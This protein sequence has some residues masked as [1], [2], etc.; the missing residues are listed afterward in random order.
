VFKDCANLPHTVG[1]VTDLDGHLTSRALESLAAEL[2]RREHLLAQAGAKDIEDYLETKMPDQEPMPR[3]VIIIDEFA[4]LVQEL[5]D[6]VAGLVDIA[7]RGRSL[8]V[9]LLLATQRPAGIVNAQ[10]KSNT[11]LRIALRVSDPADSADVIDAP[12]AA[13][14]SK[15][16]PGR[17]I[18]RLGHSSLAGFQ[19]ARVG[20]RPPGTATHDVSIWAY[21]P[22]QLGEPIPAPQATDDAD[23]VP[24]DLARLV[25]ATRQASLLSGI[26]APAPPWL[27]PL[28]DTVTLDQLLHDF[29]DALHPDQLVIPVGLADVP[30]RQCCEPAILDIPRMGHLAVAGSPRTGR[31]TLLRAVAGAVGQYLSPADV[32]IYGIDAGNNALLP[33]VGLPHTGAVVTRDQ[34]DRMERLVA[35]LQH[36]IADRQQQLAQDGYAD[37]TEQRAHA[38][39]GQQLP[40][41][42]VMFDRWE[43]FTQVY[44]SLDG[45]RL[46]DAWQQ[47]FQEGHAAGIR[48]I[49]TGDRT[50]LAGRVGALFPDK[51]LLRLSDDTDYQAIGMTS[52]HVP[53]A[54]P[55]GRCFTSA[56]ARETQILLL[57]PDPAGAAQTTALHTIA[58]QAR[59]HWVDL[60]EQTRPFRV[61]VLPTRFTLD[62]L[63][64][65]PPA[66]LSKQELPVAV[67]GDTL[68]LRAF[69]ALDNGPGLLV[70]GPRQSGRSTVLRTLAH[71][72]AAS[73]WNIIAVT[74]RRSPLRDLTGPAIK[75]QF[76]LDADPEQLAQALAGLLDQAQPGLVL[77]DDVELLGVSGPLHD[78][79][80]AHLQHLRDTGHL[81]VGAGTPNAIRAAYTGLVPDLKASR[82]GVLLSPSDPADPELFGITLPRSAIGTPL[83]AG[84]G[85]VIRSGQPERAQT[86]WPQA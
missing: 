4:A 32:H 27:P 23:A 50:L 83:P 57:D 13:Y 46:V 35:R 77:V 86:I 26:A 53:T 40:Y 9:H 38:E 11:N 29:P 12:D 56:G 25:E 84:A 76:T 60:P 66:H 45:G 78:L 28:D 82:S 68:S 48:A 14:I 19:S 37:I 30:S 85:Y 75:G 3:L 71:F 41:I 36:L 7:Q 33:L 52:K 58:T 17:A 20:G 55:P 15:T 67:A 5:P 74:P 34:P 47:I 73:G 62:Q 72:A 31:S 79:L 42:L 80:D 54:M 65:L 2:R 61:D 16:T 21:T 70:A 64:D 81:L 8:G 43:G 10:I 22:E 63:P 1:M 6:F 44:E 59:H 51:M 18:A 49:V 24:T 69:H 39:P